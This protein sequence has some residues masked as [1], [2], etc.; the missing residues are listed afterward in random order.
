MIL[1]SNKSYG[2]WGSI[3]QDNVIASA[4]L[5]V[6]CTTR[7]HQHQGRQL[8]AEGQAQARR[9]D[10]GGRRSGR[11]WRWRMIPAPRVRLKRPAGWFAAG[12]DVAAALP[13]LSDAAF[14]QDV[15]LCLNVDRHSARRATWR[16]RWRRSG[17]AEAVQERV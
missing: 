6:R 7:T 5:I 1:T 13:L 16:L 8:P 2:E 12:Q 15:F 11:R 4:I 17:A 10:A 3:F 14:R 9:L